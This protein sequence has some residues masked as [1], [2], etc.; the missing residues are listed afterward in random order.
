MLKLSNYVGKTPLIP[1]K[2]ED[3]TVWGKAELMNP[4]GSVKDRMATFILNDAEEKG[5]IKPGDYL[6]E[7]TSGNTGI[8]FA[9]LAAERGYKMVIIM[10]RNMSIERKQMFR[11]YGAELYLASEGDFDG[12]IELRDKL[13]K[14]NGWFNC[15]QFHNPLNIEAHYK[16]TGPETV[17]Y[18]H[19][20]L[21]T[22]REV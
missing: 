12:A 10:P 16:T 5:L 4:G 17:S 14:E 18:T 22:N 21:P 20:T 8:S 19:L 3:R 6:C 9:M 2:T 13:C 11:F 7:A 1:I 15:N